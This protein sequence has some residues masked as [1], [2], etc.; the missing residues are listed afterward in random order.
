MS[1]VD[2]RPDNHHD[3]PDVR[4]LIDAAL[5][6]ESE[7]EY[8]EIAWSIQRIGTREVFDLAVDLTKS[9]DAS[10]RMLGAD[11]LAS[12]GVPDKILSSECVDAL[13]KMLVADEDHDVLYSVASALGHHDDTSCVTSLIQLRQ[14]PNEIVRKGIAWGLGGKNDER[15]IQTLIELSSDPC[16]DVRDAA[17]FHLGSSPWLDEVDTPDIR[18]ALSQ[19]A[20]DNDPEI[21]AAALRGLAARG[22]RSI[23]GALIRELAQPEVYDDIVEAAELIADPELC[24]PLR[25]FQQRIGESFLMLD[26]AIAVCC[27]SCK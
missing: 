21:R 9:T 2:E 8:W 22:D 7:D 5:S 13:T 26:D 20:E 6:V 25:E 11:I 23:V 16:R 10:E 27:R 15:A 18:R 4:V 1:D 14:H 17:T 12:I 24:N 3:L 19:R